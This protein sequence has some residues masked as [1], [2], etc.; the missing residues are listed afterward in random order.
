MSRIQD[1]PDDY[2]LAAC[3]ESWRRRIGN[4]QYPCVLK[5]DV[6]MQKLENHF[7]GS[8]NVTYERYMFRKRIQEEGESFDQY[9]LLLRHAVL[10]P[11]K[12]NCSRIKLCVEY[13]RNR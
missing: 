11:W 9:L 2:Q 13:M 5:R 1:Y 6:V 10:E 12:R 3:D 4:V 8:V 7:V